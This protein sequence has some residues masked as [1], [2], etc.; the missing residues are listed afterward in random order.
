MR[1]PTSTMHQRSARP[2]GAGRTLLEPEEN[3]YIFHPLTC[4][5][6]AILFLIAPFLFSERWWIQLTTV[7]VLWLFALMAFAIGWGSLQWSRA[8]GKRDGKGRLE[9]GS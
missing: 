6:V 3:P 5:A 9:D 8:R 7:P 4:W 2:L 1:S